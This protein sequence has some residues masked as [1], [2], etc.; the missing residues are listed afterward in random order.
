[1]DV[2]AKEVLED[3]LLGYDGT[4]VFI[5]HDRYFLSQVANV[6]FEFKDGSVLRH[7]KDYYTFIGNDPAQMQESEIGR[8][9]SHRKINGDKYQICHAKQSNSDRIEATKS[10]S[11]HKNFGGSGISSGNIFKGVKNAKRYLK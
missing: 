4:V 2:T 11:K 10:K 8:K 3:A 7:D 1:M 9:L 6:I 5:S